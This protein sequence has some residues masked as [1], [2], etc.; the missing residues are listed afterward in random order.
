L[1]ERSGACL[2]IYDGRLLGDQ[3]EAELPRI[4]DLLGRDLSADEIDEVTA[5]A[6]R[7]AAIVLLEPALDANYQTVKTTTYEWS[8][9]GK[10]RRITSR[11]ISEAEQNLKSR[12]ESVAQRVIYRRALNPDPHLRSSP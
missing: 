1:G 7:I 2:Q 3:K 9:T 4:Y 8:F 5:T 12:A 10:R 6:R 11:C